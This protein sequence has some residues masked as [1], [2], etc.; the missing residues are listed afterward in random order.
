M[1]RISHS[2]LDPYLT[3]PLKAYYPK[4]PIPPWLPPEGLIGMGHVFALCGGVG[5]ALSTSTWW[6]GLLAAM[7][8]VGN[9]LADVFDGTHARA[10][11]QCR[12]G[13]ELLDHFTD[14]LSFSYWIVGMAITIE[15]LDLGLAGVICLYATALL[16]NIKAK[17]TGEFE[18]ASFGPTEFKTL[19][20]VW[21]LTHTVLLVSICSALPLVALSGYCMLLAIGIGQLV[22]GLIRGVRDVNRCETKID[23]TEW[24]VTHSGTTMKDNT[25][26]G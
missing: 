4:L 25:R 3:I 11:G 16:T 5:F 18:L 7:G 21:G 20:V 9:H 1:A 22:T 23:T 6:G 19:L 12:H 8:V 13:G 14:P 17:I 15:R 24:T 2:Y 26:D 10:T